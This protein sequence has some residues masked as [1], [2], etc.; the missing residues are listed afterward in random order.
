MISS[1]QKEII[2]T[3]EI[4]DRIICKKMPDLSNFKQVI[5]KVVHKRNG[6]LVIEVESVISVWANQDEIRGVDNL[7]VGVSENNATPYPR[8]A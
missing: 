6:F 5:G 8:S 4:N 1:I 2:M 3:I 7:T